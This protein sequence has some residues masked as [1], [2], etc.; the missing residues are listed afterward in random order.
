MPIRV[1]R[2]SDGAD[3]S[4]AIPS[5][6]RFA[7]WSRTGATLYLAGMLSV[8][9]WTPGSPVSALTSLGWTLAPNLS[10]DGAKV[11]FTVVTSTRQVRAYVYDASTGSNRLLVDQPRSSATFVKS[12]WIWML[13]EKPCI[14]SSD[15]GCFDPTEPDGKVLAF[16]LATGTESPVVFA[17]GESPTTYA[18]I[19]GDLWPSS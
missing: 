12:G 19:A 11:A 9:R 3:V 1:F 13:E 5:D 7:F 14:Q 8:S 18:L 4:P 6:F 15:H 16:N 17:N 2:L 10:P